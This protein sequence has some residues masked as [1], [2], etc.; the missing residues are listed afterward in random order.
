MHHTL[1]TPKTSV[2][3]NILNCIT[4]LREK[5]VLHMLGDS[6]N[7]IRVMLFILSLFLHFSTCN[8]IF[9][10]KCLLEVNDTGVIHQCLT[11]V[12]FALMNDTGVKHEK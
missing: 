4:F 9:L 5:T 2:Q 1:F 7:L 8:N 6:I 3:I 12:S 11:P 10:N